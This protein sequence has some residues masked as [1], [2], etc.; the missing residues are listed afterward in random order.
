MNTRFHARIVVCGYEARAKFVLNRL[1]Q[2]SVRTFVLDY[3]S[4]GVF[5]YDNNK[6]VMEEVS[7]V[8][9]LPID[10]DVGGRLVEKLEKLRGQLQDGE[11]QVLFD[12]SSC[13]RSVMAAIWLSIAESLG[14][15]ATITC[16]YALSA[17]EKAP[18][19]E[20]PSPISEPVVGDLAGWSVD[21]VKPPCAIIGLG[22]EPGRALGCM[23]YL[24][25]PEVRLFMPRGPDERFE[26]AV[27]GANAALIEETGILNLLP[28][29]VL[30]PVSTYQKLESLV[31]GLLPS[32]RPVLIPLGPKIFA[33]LC[34]VLAIQRR[35]LLCVWRT[36]AGPR[37]EEYDRQ[38][39]GEVAAF[40]VGIGRMKVSGELQEGG[41]LVADNL[42]EE[43]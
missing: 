12:V 11:L 17:F 3:G 16:T 22:F 18:T 15:Q 19:D 35:P 2:P 25:I 27:K 28:Y 1:R 26:T 32:F 29:Q 7:G 13:S 24:E 33:S 4:K 14:E 9:F 39:S 10:R 37:A 38:A 30:D 41:M 42:A 34:I 36:S 5:S 20:L 8:E 31:H 6:R 40:S 23:D 21:L 43:G